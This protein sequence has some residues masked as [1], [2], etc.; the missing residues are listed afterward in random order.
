MTRLLLAA[1]LALGAVTLPVN[2]YAQPDKVAYELQ[3]RCGKRAE[4]V[5]QKDY[6]QNITTDQY[7]TIIANYE[8]HYNAKLNKCFMLEDATSLPKGG[9]QSF[10]TLML[11]DVNE[12]KI[13]G[14]F[15]NAGAVQC[16]L[17]GR[18]CRSE[19]DWRQ[20]VAPFMNE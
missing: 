10:K 1:V 8:N 15:T 12:N 19:L 20:L 11:I 5:W 13:Y 4:Q 2:G 14:T 6:G 7:G 17:E 18:A 16:D 3:E 9:G